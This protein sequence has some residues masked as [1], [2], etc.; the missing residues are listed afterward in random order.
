MQTGKPPT[1]M[2]P[3]LHFLDYFLWQHQITGAQNQECYTLDSNA[4]IFSTG[5]VKQTEVNN[6][7]DV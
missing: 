5:S 3:A 7:T 4:G 2:K 6:I 1:Q